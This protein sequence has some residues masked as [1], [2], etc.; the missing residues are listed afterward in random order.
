MAEADDLAE[1]KTA[2]LDGRTDELKVEAAVE[3]GIELL[4][5]ACEELELVASLMELEDELEVS[6]TELAL[7]DEDELALLVG[8]VRAGS[9]TATSVL[10]EDVGLVEEESVVVVVEDEVVARVDDDEDEDEVVARTELEDEDVV[11]VVLAVV[12]VV[13]APN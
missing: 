6:L 9:V 2:E 5:V 1:D 7:E 11:V 12:V 4:K 13:A 8:S 10:D 3:L